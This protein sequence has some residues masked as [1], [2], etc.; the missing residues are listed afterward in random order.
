[1]KGSQKFSLDINNVRGW[2]ALFGFG[3]D[4][5]CNTCKMSSLKVKMYWYVLHTCGS[6]KNNPFHSI[7]AWVINTN[8][9]RLYPHNSVSAKKSL[10]RGG[11]ILSGSRLVL[12]LV[13]GLECLS[14]SIGF[15]FLRIYGFQ[16]VSMDNWTIGFQKDKK[17][18][19][20]IGLLVPI[21][22]RIVFL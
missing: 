6:S 14:S 22:I 19:T 11:T 5:I 9:S 15:G 17:K 4:R 16:T 12:G 20:D 10:R 21:V 2:D 3:I 7:S 8:Y 1:M 13:L 18:L